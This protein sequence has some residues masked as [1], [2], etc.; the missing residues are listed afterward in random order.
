M[1][2]Y[3]NIYF[4]KSIFQK[5]YGN[6]D[7]QYYGNMYSN[8]KSIKDFNKLFDKNQDL[9]INCTEC[10]KNKYGKFIKVKKM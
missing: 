5:G 7:I 3:R 4:L 9:L 1:K 10:A 2:L 6:N 8:T